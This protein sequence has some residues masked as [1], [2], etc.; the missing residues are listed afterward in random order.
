VR[1]E[2]LYFSGCPNHQPAV[3]RVRAVLAREGEF[4]DLTEVEVPNP[5][6]AQRLRFLGSPTIRINGLDIEKS[7]RRS[8]FIGWS[9]RTYNHQGQQLGLPPEEWIQAAIH[10]AKRQVP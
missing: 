3:N 4:A 1:I 10:E 9:C 6:A 8:Q 5:A 2:I 7:A